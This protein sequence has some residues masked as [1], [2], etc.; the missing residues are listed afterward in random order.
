MALVIVTAGVIYLSFKQWQDDTLENKQRMAFD[1]SS[2]SSR[3]VVC[4]LCKACCTEAYRVCFV[5]A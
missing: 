3:C 1:A 4:Q 5:E 2:P